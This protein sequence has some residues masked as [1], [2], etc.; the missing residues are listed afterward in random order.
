MQLLQER[1]RTDP[2]G[3]GLAA[4]VG[5]RAPHPQRQHR[6]GVCVALLEAREVREFGVLKQPTP[7]ILDR[8][9][10]SHRYPVS[11]CERRLGLGGLGTSEMTRGRVKYLVQSPYM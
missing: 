11:Q 4:A 5:Y 10:V 7:N 3:R 1:V 9:K 8:K 2:D 6:V